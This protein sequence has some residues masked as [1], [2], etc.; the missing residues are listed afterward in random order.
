MPEIVDAYYTESGS[1]NVVYE[2]QPSDMFISIP[3]DPNNKDFV[4]IMEWAEQEGNE[5][6]EYEAPPPPP[7][8]P[9]LEERV[10]AL[11][12]RSV[13]LEGNLSTSVKVE[14]K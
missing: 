8:V 4:A 2:G 10:A 5:I 6:R 11:E 1:I 14:P 3:P 13:D 9:T 7:A 12:R